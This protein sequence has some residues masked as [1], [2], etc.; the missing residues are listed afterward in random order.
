MNNDLCINYGITDC[1][2]TNTRGF[3][4]PTVWK[5]RAAHLLETG[6]KMVAGTV[7]AA[8]AVSTAV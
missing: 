4:A 2:R 1:S 8:V 5:G 7:D 3:G 6:P